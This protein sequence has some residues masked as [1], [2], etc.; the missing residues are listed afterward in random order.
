MAKEIRLTYYGVEGCGPTVRE[1]KENAGAEIK[2]IIDRCDNDPLLVRLRDQAILIYPRTSGWTHSL[3]TDDKGA[4]RGTGNGFRPHGPTGYGSFE[5]T[6]TA[7]IKHLAHVAWEFGL[8]DADFVATVPWL[9]DNDRKDLLRYFAWQ[10]RYKAAADSGH[11]PAECH[12]IA[13]RGEP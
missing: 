4:L 11:T 10:R 6:R 5:E 3:I 8:N 1:A 7:A 13:S 9:T 2:R 12:D